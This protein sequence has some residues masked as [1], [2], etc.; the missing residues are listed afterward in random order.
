MRNYVAIA[1]RAG[2]R[3]SRHG[4]RYS[5]QQTGYA[6]EVAEEQVADGIAAVSRRYNINSSRIFLAG[7]GGGGTM[8][9]RLAWNDPGRI[10]GVVALNGPLPTRW[11][12]LHRLNDARRVPCLLVASRENRI[13]T[14]DQMCRDLRLLHS[15]GCTVALRQYP[16]ADDLTSNM[17][18][19]MNRW[20]ME[21]V[22][23]G[24]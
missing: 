20:L 9:L 14:A 4:N 6:I 13:Y 24:K 7:C 5:W 2:S 1:P 3:S 21:L 11:R 8:A 12:P 16:G 22:C 17:L 18:S 15:A 10:A 19:D 23:G